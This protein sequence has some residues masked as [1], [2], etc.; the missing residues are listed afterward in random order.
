M[1]LVWKGGYGMSMGMKCILAGLLLV[2][3]LGLAGC[4]EVRAPWAKEREVIQTPVPADFA[5]VLEENQDTYYSRMHIRQVVTASDLMSRTTWTT[6]RDANNTVASE[7]TTE[8]SLTPAQVQAMWNEV[9]RYKLMEGASTWYYWMTF[10]DTYRREEHTM[11]IKADGKMQSYKQLNHW[12][13]KFQ[14]LA[15][16][17]EG[18]RF[19]VPPRGG[20]IIPATRPAETQSGTEPEKVEMPATTRAATEP[21]GTESA[22][23]PA[24]APAT[25]PAATQSAS[26]LK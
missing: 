15:L 22:I 21:A 7:F 11:Q 2:G 5:V 23:E 17:V 16:L 1:A 24:S 26:Q 9:Q 13:Y 18:V 25:A 4:G 8:H 12:G 20:V 19:D 3:G 10:P 6:L 14:D